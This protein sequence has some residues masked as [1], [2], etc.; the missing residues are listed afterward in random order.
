MVE[1]DSY[2]KLLSP[3]ILDIYM[4]KYAV[5]RHTVAALH[6]YTRPTCLRVWGSGSLIVTTCDVKMMSFRHC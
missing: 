6:S 1:A 5:R 2:L 4:L 3:S